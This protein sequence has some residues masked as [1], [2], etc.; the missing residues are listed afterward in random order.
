MSRYPLLLMLFLLGLS[1]G[2]GRVVPV[3]F[4]MA[5]ASV[6]FGGGLLIVGVVWIVIAAGLFRRRGTTL[7]PTKAPDQLVIDGLYRWSRNPM[8]VGMLWILIGS[9]FALNSVLSFLCP[10]IFFVW[11]NSVVIPREELCI[12][13]VFGEAYLRYKQ[14]TRRWI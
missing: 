12:E 14:Q 4:G 2:V 3:P 13:S 9:A 5:R 10:V 6:F 7:D 8:Y 11:M 1:Y